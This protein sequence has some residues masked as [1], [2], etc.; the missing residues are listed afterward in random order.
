MLNPALKATIQ[1]RLNAV[2]M[3]QIHLAKQLGMTLALL[4]NALSGPIL[5]SEK[6]VL[7]ILDALDSGRPFHPRVGAQRGM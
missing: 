4:D 7:A 2:N 1:A 3:M 6:Y 5:E